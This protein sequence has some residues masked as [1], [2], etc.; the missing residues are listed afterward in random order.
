MT[1]YVITWL[2][3][4]I[5]NN[6]DMEIGRGDD[7]KFRVLFIFFQFYNVSNLFQNSLDSF[8]ESSR[9]FIINFYSNFRTFH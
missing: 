4:H 9:F 6:N 2:I 3:L 1:V 5:E 8:C 7:Y